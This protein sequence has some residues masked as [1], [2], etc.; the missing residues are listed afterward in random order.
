MLRS[1]RLVLGGL[2]LLAATGGEARSQYYYPGGYGYGG[3]GFGGWGDTAAGQHRSGAWAPTPRAQGVYNY[4]T[5]VAD[6]IDADTVMRFNQ[7]LYNSMLE[8][9]RRY[10][11]E[12]AGQAEH[13]RRPLQGPAVPG[14]ATTR[15]RTTSTPAT[16]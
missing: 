8:A 1:I 11:A 16:P 3:Y 14:S 6:S 4:D 10:N 13:G 2:A 7:Y 15:P 5:A 12:H 9:R